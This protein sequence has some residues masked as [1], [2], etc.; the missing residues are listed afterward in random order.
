MSL[1]KSWLIPGALAVVAVA[2]LSLYGETEK[3]EADLTG[4]ALTILEQ[5]DM[6]WAKITFHGRDATLTG[7]APEKGAAEEASELLLAEWG[8]RVVK[9]KTGLLAAQSPYTWGLSRQGNT[10]TMIGYLPYYEL[11]KAPANIEAAIA[12]AELEMSSVEAARGAPEEISGA[13]RLA[14]TLLAELPD[15]KVMLIDDKLTISGTLANDAEG[16]DL[17]NRLKHT[18]DN[19]DLGAIAVDLQIRKPQPDSEGSSNLESLTET[20]DTTTGSIDPD[21][22][23]Q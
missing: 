13:V 18:A 20:E 4:R 9:D 17:Y 8:V 23:Q 14:G 12:D 3:I 15:G 19:I 1:L 6:D 2:G 11:K 10:V 7:I 5:R 22:R 21:T 16:L